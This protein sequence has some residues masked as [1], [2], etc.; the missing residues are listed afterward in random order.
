[1]H[2][3]FT[4]ASALRTAQQALCGAGSSGVCTQLASLSHDDFLN[5]YLKNVNFTYTARERV[6]S[7]A[8]DQYAPYKAAKRLQFD[9]RGDIVNPSFSLWNYNDLPTG[10]ETTATFKFREVGSG[11][12][13]YVRLKCVC[14]C[15]CVCV[16]VCV[17][18]CTCVY[19]HVCMCVCVCVCVH[20]H[21]CVCANKCVHE[22]L[23]VHVCL[24]VCVCV[25]VN[26][27]MGQFAW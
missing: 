19:M 22:C 27:Y 23:C 1:M 9:A 8:S 10:E 6:P 17:R 24:C 16:C 18:V 15:V 5:T 12:W 4:Y 7:L 25:C 14:M 13:C 2:A 11:S 26:T 3:V 20:A 21:I